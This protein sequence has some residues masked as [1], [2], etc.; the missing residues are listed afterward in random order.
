MYNMSLPCSVR[1]SSIEVKSML[2]SPVVR[3]FAR[4]SGL[5][6]LTN[7]YIRAGSAELPA[8]N[9]INLVQKSAQEHLAHFAA[10][11]GLVE[12]LFEVNVGKTTRLPAPCAKPVSV[13]PLDTRML[14]RMRFS[15]VCPG[16]DGWRMEYLVR[17]T[18]SAKVLVVAL[19]VTAGKPLEKE[20]LSLERRDV[21]AVPDAVSD[22]R[23]A[24]GQ[25]SRRSLRAGELLR[26]SQL[27]AAAAVKRGDLVR[28][29]A[30]RDQIEVST[31]GEAQ[32]GGPL[33]SVI[34][35]RNTASGQVIRARIVGAGAVEPVDL[36]GG[37]QSPD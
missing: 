30:R 35:V 33:Q 32:D 29:I 1:L 5:I 2:S 9:T 27:T 17:A 24:V 22:V 21:T 10:A 12:P 4:I 11:A 18:L 16:G 25:A 14:N 36:P 8:D 37:T 19:P 31:N 7:V 15:A 34:R 13:E 23:D 3:R 26:S 6:L 28:I 20:Q